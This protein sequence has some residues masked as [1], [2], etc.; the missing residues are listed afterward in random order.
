MFEIKIR[1][2]YTVHTMMEWLNSKINFTKNKKIKRITKK[3]QH[4]EWNRNRNEKKV[5]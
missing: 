4:R 1:I 2:D 3:K 5:I